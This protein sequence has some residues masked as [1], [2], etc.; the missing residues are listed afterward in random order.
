MPD[1][2][3]LSADWF[4]RGLTGLVTAALVF[5]A[6]V[7][8]DRRSAKNAAGATQAAADATL[9]TS[10]N[11]RLSTFME[12]Q[13]RRV[14]DLEGEIADLRRHMASERAECERQLAAM[15]AEIA[16]LMGGPPATYTE[17]HAAHAEQ[18]GR[19]AQARQANKGKTE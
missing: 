11:K 1:P 6:T 18:V 17:R 5:L 19:A 13:E 2:T 12:A 4:G 3:P 10:L 8:R 7:L 16:A 15:R 14:K 9:S